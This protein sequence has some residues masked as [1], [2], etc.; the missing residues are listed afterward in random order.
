M[1]AASRKTITGTKFESGAGNNGCQPPRYN[2]VATQVMVTMLAYSDMKKQANFMLLY[3][4][5]KPATSSFS[6]SGKSNGTR[7][8]SAKPAIMNRMNEK[9]CGNGIWKMFQRGMKPR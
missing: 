2:N 1:P 3:S 9:I 7:F 5:W 6:A 8:V 4:V